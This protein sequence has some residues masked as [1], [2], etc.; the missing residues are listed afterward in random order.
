[1]EIDGGQRA[2]SQVTSGMA[3]GTAR[4]VRSEGLSLS[5]RVAPRV[6]G[7]RAE[8]VCARGVRDWDAQLSF[9]FVEHV[10]S[11]DASLPQLLAKIEHNSGQTLPSIP[12][13]QLLSKPLHEDTKSNLKELTEGA[14]RC[15]MPEI[16]ER[17]RKA[18]QQDM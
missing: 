3:V 15:R 6:A 16:E 7:L 14:S 17:V 4:G 8:L 2:T 5:V 13:K 10:R 9:N 12:K 11:L 1:M 18:Y